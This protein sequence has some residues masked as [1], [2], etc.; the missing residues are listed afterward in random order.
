MKFGL[1]TANFGNKYGILNKKLSK[2][3]INFIINSKKI[4]IIDTAPSYKNAEKIIGLNLKNKKKIISKISPFKSKNMEENLENFKK[5]FK[6]TLKNLDQKSIYALLFHDEKDILRKKINIF[7][8]YLNSL[9]KGGIIKK[10]GFSTYDINKSEK[11]LKVFN[12]EIIQFPINAFTIDKKKIKTL[13]KLKNKKIELHARTIFLQ[14]II[15]S[16][17]IE[18]NKFKIL[19]KKLNIIKEYIKSNKFKKYDFFINSVYLPKLINCYILGFSTSSDINDFL[20]FKKFKI[21]TEFFKKINIGSNYI[22]D[23]RKWKK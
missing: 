23:P 14:G 10:I 17:K 4:S 18:K 8:K 19:I 6:S 9:K 2:K 15:F 11:F 20:K 22:T 13:K 5:E 21:N 3:N 12:F 7:L 1:G 16:K